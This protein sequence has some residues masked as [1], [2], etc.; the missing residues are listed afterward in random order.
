M[1][2]SWPNSLLRKIEIPYSHHFFR[3][4]SGGGVPHFSSAELD[5]ISADFSP[6]QPPSFRN[7]LGY[8][9]FSQLSVQLQTSASH[10]LLIRWRALKWQAD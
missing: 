9:L 6:T 8:D 3:A 1:K 10:G 7:T 5:P 2:R 4:A